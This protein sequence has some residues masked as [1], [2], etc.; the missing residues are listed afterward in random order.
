MDRNI[1]R[2][3]TGYEKGKG[4]LFIITRITWNCIIIMSSSL[5]G[6][7]ILVEWRRQVH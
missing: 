1:P 5:E 6:D 3:L 4:F 7:A 2:V